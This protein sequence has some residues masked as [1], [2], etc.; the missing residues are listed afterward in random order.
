MHRAARQVGKAVLRLELRARRP[1][2]VMFLFVEERPY[3]S[4]GEAPPLRAARILQVR[5]IRARRRDA[6]G[7]AA[8]RARRI[9]RTPGR[10][11]E[12]PGRRVTSAAG[13]PFSV[14]QVLVGEVGDRRRARDAVA[15]EVRHQV[16]VER[17]L[18]GRQALEQREHVAALRRGDEV[19]GVL[20]AG[21][22]RLA[23]TRACR[24]NSSPSH[25]ASSAS[26]TG[27]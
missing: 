3:F 2:D 26:E 23:A 6:C 11:S 27:V 20:D 16:E 4:R 19:V 12:R 1:A 14:L 21:L 13:L 17:Q 15:R 22:D 5:G 10:S 18:V 24:P 25:A 8:R 7:R 9:R